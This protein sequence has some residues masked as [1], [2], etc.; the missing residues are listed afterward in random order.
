MFCNVAGQILIF[1]VWA[2]FFFL[3]ANSTEWGHLY[4]AATLK[5]DCDDSGPL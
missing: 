4:V 3:S 1:L 5:K 2:N